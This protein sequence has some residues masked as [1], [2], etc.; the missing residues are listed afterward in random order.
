MVHERIEIRCCTNYNE[1]CQMQV[2]VQVQVQMLEEACLVLL[3][4]HPVYII[5]C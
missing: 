3:G 1:I 5:I 2:Q 4:F